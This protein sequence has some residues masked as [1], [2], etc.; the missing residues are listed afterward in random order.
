MPSGAAPCLKACAASVPGS[1]RFDGQ[2]SV[3]SIWIVPLTMVACDR[4][5]FDNSP[6]R[7]QVDRIDY[8]ERLRKAGVPGEQEVLGG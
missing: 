5:R 4:V 1:S 3:I 6:M 8:A 7:R 2:A